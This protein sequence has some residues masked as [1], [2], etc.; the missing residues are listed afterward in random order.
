MLHEQENDPEPG[1]DEMFSHYYALAYMLRL[2]NGEMNIFAD[3]L[4]E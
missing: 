1:K 2:L 3:K 4:I